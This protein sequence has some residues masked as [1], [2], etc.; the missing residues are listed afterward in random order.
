MKKTLLSLVALFVFGAQ[1]A[2][3]HDPRSVAKEFSH[4]LKIDGAGTMTLTYKSLHF[5][6]PAYNGL[7]T[8]AQRR[9]QVLG[10]LWKKIGTLETGFDVVLNGVQV[11]KGK[12]DFGLWF[13][14]KDNFKF[15]LN[16]G[17]KELKIDATTGLDT[18]SVTWMSFDIRPT[19]TPDTFTLEGRGGKFRTSV[20]VKVPFLADHSHDKDKK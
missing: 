19:D 15:L 3:A 13:D 18:M 9:E 12:Y 6:E 2:G 8:N 16:G 14:D 5:N 1:A 11:A 10:F 20:P 4:T 7:K 17:G